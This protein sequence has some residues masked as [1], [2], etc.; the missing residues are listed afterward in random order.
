MVPP[1]ES[2]SAGRDGA[3]NGGGMNIGIGAGFGSNLCVGGAA[4]IST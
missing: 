3:A 2:N 4:V 1:P